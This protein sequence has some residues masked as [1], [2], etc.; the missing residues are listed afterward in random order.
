MMKN[1]VYFRVM[2]DLCKLVECDV[3]KG[4]QSGAKSQKIDYLSRLFLYRTETQYS[5]Y[6]PHKVP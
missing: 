2:H 6:A 4:T 5:C 1:G 3:T